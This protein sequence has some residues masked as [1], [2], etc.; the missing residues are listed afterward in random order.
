MPRGDGGT[1]ERY[2]ACRGVMENG[3]KIFTPPRGDGGTE[4]RYLAC[5]GVMGER[6]EDIYPGEG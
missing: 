4:E 3:R 5:R 6:K 1:E 2:L